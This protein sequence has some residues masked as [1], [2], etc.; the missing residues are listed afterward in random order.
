MPSGPKTAGLPSGVNSW[1]QNIVQPKIQAQQQQRQ[2]LP[3][4]L[5]QFLSKMGFNLPSIQGKPAAM[6]PSP[7]PAP[8]MMDTGGATGTAM[9]PITGTAMPYGMNSV[10][11]NAP[12]AGA[13]AAPITNTPDTSN[14]T[15]TG[16]MF[17]MPKSRPAAFSGGAN[18]GGWLSNVMGRR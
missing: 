1:W 18:A 11:P 15:A 9:P 14:Y 5:T 16:S 7:M 17:N 8:D 12:G 13:S 3:D 4:V 2:Q 6:Q 10:D